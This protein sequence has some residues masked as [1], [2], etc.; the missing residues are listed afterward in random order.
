MNTAARPV[1]QTA[2]S[3]YVPVLVVVILG[4][5]ISIYNICSMNVGIPSF[6]RIFNSDLATAQW[7]MT[8]FT[9]TAGVITPITG[10]LGE[11]FSNKNL[12]LFS[13]AGLLVSS[14]LCSISWNIYA[15]IVFRMLQGIFCGLIQ[16]VTL[17][18]IF[19]VTPKPKQTM[20]VSLWSASTILGPALAPTISGWLME[21]QWPWMFLVLIPLCLLTLLLGWRTIP[22]Q[23][24][25]V[26]KRLDGWGL[27]YAVAGSLALLTFFTNVYSWGFASGAS[28]LF[29]SIGLSAILLFV[30]LELRTKEPLLQ[31]RLFR[32]RIFTASITVSAVLIVGLYSGIYFIPLYLQ[33][34]HQMSP[35]HVGLLLLLPAL[36]LGVATIAAGRWYDRVGPLRLVLAGGFLVVFASWMFSFLQLD[37][38]YTYVAVWMAV[39]YIGIGLSLTPAMNA[40]MQAVPPELYGH[41]SALINWL[42]QIFGALA[43]G[44]FTSIFYARMNTHTHVLQHTAADES[45]RWIHLTAYTMSI[46]DAFLFAAAFSFIGLPLAFM[47]RTQRFGTAKKNA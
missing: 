6:I 23:R 20:A 17:T 36:T 41:A 31:L 42:R 10:Y 12:F 15:L 45:S 5:F 9:L 26:P 35:S 11:K 16:P 8:G 47:L 19:Q 33:E 4:S 27:A 29:L 38:S 7:L 37:T 1:K 34:I 39:R 3:S 21:H 43:L 2:S 22:F 46:D 13:I 25:N 14:I 30:I 24:G 40:G 44:L 18:I 32:N 28:V